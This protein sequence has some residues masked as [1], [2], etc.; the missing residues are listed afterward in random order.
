MNK[1]AHAMRADGCQKYDHAGLKPTASTG[2][3]LRP[4]SIT[5][6]VLNVFVSELCHVCVVPVTFATELPA[7]RVR[8]K[9]ARLVNALL[10]C[11]DADVS[12]VHGI[13]G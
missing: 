11:L 5:L 10:V 6:T 3:R 8:L 12:T 9:P 7:E 13:L 4:V 2:Q 1:G